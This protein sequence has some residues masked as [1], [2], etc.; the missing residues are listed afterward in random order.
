MITKELFYIDAYIKDF[1]A[2]VK[3]CE[4]TENGYKI[5]LDQTAFFYE[6]GG[7][8]CDTGT[9]D[10]VRV[11]T[12]Q[13]ENGEIYHYTENALKIGDTVNGAVDFERRFYFMQNHSGEHIVSGIV[14]KKFGLDNV[15]FHLNE[16]FVTLDFNGILSRA[17]LDEIELLANKVVWENRSIKTYF[18]SE[19]E[20]EALPYRSKKELEGDIRIVEVEGV[21]MCACCAPHVA[22][23]GE[24]GIIKLLE[25]EKL[26]G[27]TRIYMKCG[28]YALLDYQNT[29]KNLLGISN[30]LSAKRENSYE[31]FGIFKAKLDEEKQLNTA[32]K[33][34]FITVLVDAVNPDEKAVFAEDF[35]MKELQ[36]LADMLHKK[37]G[38]IRMAVSPSKVGCAFA[39]CGEEQELNGYFEELKSRLNIRGGGR[40][41][42]ISGSINEDLE[43]IKEILWTG[44]K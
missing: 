12:V 28:K 24:I 23:T 32:L 9:L 20:L 3:S 21:D 40:N 13:K 41:G 2:V 18:P 8:P 43:K 39:L 15:G 36:S 27:G 37:Y 1:T 14:N 25:F 11:L 29:Y 6:G 5:G 17:Q 35:E 16:E 30:E 42:M 22:K 19:S 33:K 31:I 4:K 34:R 7:Q 26:R 44:Q 10:G 38:G